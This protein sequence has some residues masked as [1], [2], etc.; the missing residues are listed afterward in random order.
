[1]LI[2]SSLY[3]FGTRVIL[4][5][6]HMFMLQA[7]EMKPDDEHCLVTRSKC[8]LQLGNS[9]AALTDAEAA[10]EINPKLIKVSYHVL[11]I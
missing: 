5:L 11:S 4:N 7:L 1:M 2:R 3:E 8:Y 9:Q 10:L 6:S